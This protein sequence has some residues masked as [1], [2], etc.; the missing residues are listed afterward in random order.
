M[1]ELKDVLTYIYNNYPYKDK[2]SKA[3]LVKMLYLADW[4]SAITQGKQLTS[5]SWKFSENGPKPENFIE[6]IS[7][8]DETKIK[9]LIDFSYASLTNEDKEVINHV[10]VTTFEKSWDS[11]AS[12]IYSTF[13]IFTQPRFSQ[14]NLV[15]LAKIYKDI[16]TE[17]AWAAK[18]NSDT[19]TH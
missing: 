16:Q 11:F 6:E 2:L 18:I 5:I 1:S 7:L 10:I 19:N 14:L 17:L 12:L 8:P 15:Q 13:P 3:R 9:F 4:R